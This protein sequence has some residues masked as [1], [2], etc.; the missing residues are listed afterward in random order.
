VFPKITEKALAWLDRQSADKPFFLYF[1]LTAPHTPWVPIRDFE[2]RSQVG[3]YGDFVAQVDAVVG[4][5]LETLAKKGLAE[6]TLVILTSDN[7]SHWPVADIQKWGHAANLHYRGQKSDIWEGGHRVPYIARWP[8]RIPAG[9]ACDE[10]I[11]HVDFWA[12]A[13]ALVGHAVPAD[14]AEDSFSH[15]P[16]LLGQAR[17]EPIRP[18][19]VHHSGMGTF[20]LRQGKWKLVVDNLGSGGFSEPRQVPPEPGGPQG[21]LYD[22]E[23]DSRETTNVYEKHPDVVENLRR[24]LSEIRKNGRST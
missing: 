23:Q 22:L 6:N 2:G 8:G 9:S 12:T 24:S 5:V 14:A 17:S 7:G 16:A 13:A 18:A 21:Q 4:Q 3:Y 20:A 15:L 19:T 10:T 1:P 11:C